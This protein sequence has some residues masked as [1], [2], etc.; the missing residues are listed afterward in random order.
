MSPRR[1]TPQARSALVDIAARL[2]AEEGP[3]ALSTRRL[4]AEAGSSTMAVY[5]HFGG[6]S[7][8]VRE[9]VHEGFARLQDFLTGVG[10]TDDPVADMA[11]LGRAYR[12][13][14]LANT[15]LYPV[16]FGGLSLAGYTLSE[17]DR[18]HGRY[19]LANVARCAGRCMA[20]GRFA[21]GDPDLVAHHMWIAT[22]G[23]V[24]LE[25]G[26]YLIEPFTADG[27]FE[28]QLVGMM[29]SAGDRAE[30]ARRSVADSAARLAEVA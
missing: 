5:T 11:L 26:E 21:P 1:A 3:A 19:T 13:N 2:L 7:G 18:H 27:V 10:Q 23:L 30:T 9:M 29:V 14:A 17:E 4:A 24:T 20:A 12:G 6:M 22:H 25:L 28:S 8:L 15:H 16:M